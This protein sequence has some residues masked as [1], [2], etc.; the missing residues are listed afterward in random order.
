MTPSLT[1]SPTGSSSSSSHSL[2]Y[3]SYKT[4]ILNLDD[5]AIVETTLLSLPHA[6]ELEKQLAKAPVSAAAPVISQIHIIRATAA[7]ELRLKEIEDDALR[8][9][10]QHLQRQIRSLEIQ[11]LPSAFST[12]CKSVIR[13]IEERNKTEVGRPPSPSTS[14]PPS[15]VLAADTAGEETQPAAQPTPVEEPLPIPEPTV[16]FK[17]KTRRGATV[18]GVSKTRASKGKKREVID[19]TEAPDVITVKQPQF[20][21]DNFVCRV[22]KKLGHRH[23]NCPEYFCRICQAQKPGHLS[24]YC[25]YAAKKELFPLVYTDEGFYE[26]LAAWEARK[27]E[28]LLEEIERA[29]RDYATRYNEPEFCNADADPI[30]YDYMNEYCDNEE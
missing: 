19:L 30:H 17:R 23:K 24:I 22:C 1:P 20:S 8:L 21:T 12:I 27:D 10:C 28:E 9:A 3:S 14:A 13:T 6:I 25:P 15:N 4:N 11:L 2:G 29:N 18:H 7:L 5:D 26:A 16:V